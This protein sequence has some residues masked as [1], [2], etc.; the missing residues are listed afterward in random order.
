[1]TEMPSAQVF[2]ANE[3]KRLARNLE[4]RYRTLQS[5]LQ[6]LIEQLQNGDFPGDQVTG[7]GYSGYKVRVKNST[8]RKGKSGGYRVIYQILSPDAVVLLYLYSKS[9]Q[10]DV[11]TADLLS[12]IEK[13]QI[14]PE[15]L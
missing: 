10:D 4:K 7:A 11:A 2:V 9:D 8:I 13:F 6:P 15:S 12:I 3:F 5:D 1:M 14:P